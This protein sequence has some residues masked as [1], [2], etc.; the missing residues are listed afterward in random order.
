MDDLTTVNFGGD[1][2]ITK[3]DVPAQNVFGWASVIEKD[4]QAVVD[5]QG[6]VIEAAE[7]EA[8]AYDYVLESRESGDMHDKGPVRGRIIESMVFTPDKLDA[9]GIAK[10][11]VP[12]GW[13]IGVHI[14][15][16]DL[17]EKVRSGERT[18]FSIEGQAIRVPVE[19]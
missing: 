12:T 18:A 17:F 6:D 3:A 5:H 7:L 9:L 8:A 4:G 11:S 19:D 16:A 2:A 14:D 15:D 13:W 10:G 1:L